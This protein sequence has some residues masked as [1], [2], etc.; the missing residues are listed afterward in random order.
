MSPEQK[1]FIEHLKRPVGECYHS[2][3]TGQGISCSAAQ[4][5]AVWQVYYGVAEALRGRA[6]GIACDIE[7]NQHVVIRSVYAPQWEGLYFD[8]S[9]TGELSSLSEQSAPDVPGL[10]YVA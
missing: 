10:P 5:S 6:E 4:I 9:P 8:V 7:P 3:P 1:Q 2:L